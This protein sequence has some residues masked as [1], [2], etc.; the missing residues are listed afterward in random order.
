MHFNDQHK[1]LLLTFLIS[2]TV[3]LSI[4]NLGLKKHNEFA[5][6]SYYELEPEKE[7]TEEDIK[8]LEALEKLN[9]TKAETNEAFDQSQQNKHFAQAYKTIAPPEDFIPKH[10][11]NTTDY[12]KTINERHN[13]ATQDSKLNEEELSKFNKANEI[14]KKQLSENNNSKSSIGFSLVNRTKVYIPIPVYLCEVD[15]KIVVNITV[16]SNGDVIDAYINTSS[17]SNNECLIEHAL[18][19]AKQSKFSI[20]GSKKTQIGSITFSFIGK[21]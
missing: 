15:G 7:L 13:N 2:G 5:S 14:L 8:V 9:N 20:D 16:N 11:D 6:E 10:D 18:D 19:Y 1:A 21:Y 4:F 3:V 17:T 12:L